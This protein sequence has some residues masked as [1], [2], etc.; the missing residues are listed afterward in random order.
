MHTYIHTDLLP[1]QAHTYFFGTYGLGLAFFYAISN[2]LSIHMPFR[3]ACRFYVSDTTYVT[4]CM[5]IE[6]PFGN[7][8]LKKKKIYS[9]YILLNISHT[10]QRWVKCSECWFIRNSLFVGVSVRNIRVAKWS[11]GE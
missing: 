9:K 8:L 3:H 10:F 1:T 11:E 7:S 2:I 5:Y 6:R 4:I